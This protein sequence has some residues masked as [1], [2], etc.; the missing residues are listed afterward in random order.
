M[1]SLRLEIGILRPVKHGQV[2]ATWSR[3]NALLDIPLIA[4]ASFPL[5]QVTTTLGLSVAGRRLQL[6]LDPP[7]GSGSLMRPRG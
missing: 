1:A 6:T 7:H 2:A 5:G 3:R 4:E